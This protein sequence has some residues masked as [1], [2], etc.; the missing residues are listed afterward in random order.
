M[1][2]KTTYHGQKKYFLT[3][4]PSKQLCVP[5][6][7]WTSVT[8]PCSKPE[9]FIIYKTANSFMN[10]LTLTW[11]QLNFYCSPFR[12]LTTTSQTKEIVF[13]I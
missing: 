13:M 3:L 10:T 1:T 11:T 7:L 2:I 5:G 4:L 12:L 6:P 8:V 9:C